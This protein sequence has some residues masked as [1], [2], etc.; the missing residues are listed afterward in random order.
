MRKTNAANKNAQQ[1]QIPQKN[2]PDA[3]AAHRLPPSLQRNP[4]AVVETSSS[5]MC[6]AQ[7]S[8]ETAAF[9]FR[10]P[11]H[12]QKMDLVCCSP[13]PIPACEEIH[14]EALPVQRSPA[15]KSGR[16]GF[17][18][19]AAVTPCALNAHSRSCCRPSTTDNKHNPLAVRRRADGGQVRES[20]HKS[21][22][23]EC[24]VREVGFAAAWNFGPVM[25]WNLVAGVVKHD[26]RHFA[27]TRS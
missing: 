25:W 13:L 15:D 14:K 20:C 3:A 26:L 11:A 16:P 23:A 12:F 1:V 22:V 17:I 9:Y 19:I 24:L 10:F 4:S 27:V 18:I 7:S 8:E 2:R 6:P 21:E 5:T